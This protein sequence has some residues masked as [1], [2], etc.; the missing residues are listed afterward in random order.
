MLHSDVCFVRSKRKTGAQRLSAICA[1]LNYQ[2]E[3]DASAVESDIASCHD[4]ISQMDFEDE[5]GGE[6][7]VAEGE[8]N[9]QWM[10]YN[11]VKNLKNSLGQSLSEP[12]MKL[13]SK[14]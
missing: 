14:R 1:A 8:D 7:S 11:S 2:S 4:N 9:V 10:L 12:F 5:S 13:P 6:G 3:E